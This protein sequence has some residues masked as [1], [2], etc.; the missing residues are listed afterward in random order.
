M[1]ASGII[2][3]II[4]GN[5]DDKGAFEAVT[6]PSGLQHCHYWGRMLSRDN[7]GVLSARP[8]DRLRRQYVNDSAAIAEPWVR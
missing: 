1:H 5:G 4:E 7:D 3:S 8:R 6:V 2:V